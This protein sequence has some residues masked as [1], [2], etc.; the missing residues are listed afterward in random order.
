MKMLR[1]DHIEVNDHEPNVICHAD[2]YLALIDV[3]ALIKSASNNGVVRLLISPSNIKPLNK[4]S[5]TSKTTVKT[6][7]LPS[8]ND[9]RMYNDGNNFD[10]YANSWSPY[11]GPLV[12]QY[13]PPA[14]SMVKYMSTSRLDNTGLAP[15]PYQERPYSANGFDSYQRQ[16]YRPTF[17]T[18]QPYL[19]TD[20][21]PRKT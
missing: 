10:Q 4:P 14:S 12:G 20:P 11:D 8:L 9:E 17:L 1:K 5:S 6:K 3:V 13:Q 21:W 2:F 19:P 18:S 7:S 16:P 15:Q